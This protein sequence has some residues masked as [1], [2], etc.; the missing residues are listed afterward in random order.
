MERP[1]QSFS[2][3]PRADTIKWPWWLYPENECTCSITNQTHQLW[4]FCS[5]NSISVSFYS[6][7][8]IILEHKYVWH[9]YESWEHTLEKL[10]NLGFLNTEST[11][12]FSLEY[13]ALMQWPGC[14]IQA[15]QGQSCSNY[16]EAAGHPWA[17]KAPIPAARGL[18]GNTQ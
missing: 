3:I 5:K 8:S 4:T 17:G 16:N 12:C 1:N 15:Q 18:S 6:D 13:T 14:F 7:Y 10:N 2:V 11:A 9:N